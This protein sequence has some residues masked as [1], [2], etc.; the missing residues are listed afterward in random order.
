MWPVPRERKS[1]TEAVAHHGGLSA[2]SPNCTGGS[3]YA[4]VHGEC[5]LY[6]GP[7][8]G[9]GISSVIDSLPVIDALPAVQKEAIRKQEKKKKNG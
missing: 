1:R 9:T 4:E 5:L 8:L 6:S 3:V 2:P 7:D